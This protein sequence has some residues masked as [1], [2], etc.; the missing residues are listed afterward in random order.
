MNDE[1][2]PIKVWTSWSSVL[3]ADLDALHERLAAVE[4]LIKRLRE[5]ADQRRDRA[6]VYHNDLANYNYNKGVADGLS[7][8]AWKLDQV[9]QETDQ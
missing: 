4:A 1:R 6:Q 7:A 9:L 3:T 8:A 2:E 5:N